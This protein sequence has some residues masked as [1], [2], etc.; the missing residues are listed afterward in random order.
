MRKKLVFI[1]LILLLVVLTGCW[2]ARELNELGLSLIIGLDLEDDKVLLTAEIINP[3]YSH[4]STVTT[5]QGSFVK[6]IQGTGNN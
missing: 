4:Q 2:N 5:G 1:E 3:T 6:Y